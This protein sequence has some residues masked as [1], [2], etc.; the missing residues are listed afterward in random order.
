M[1]KNIV[2]I[3]MF[4]VIGL[5]QTN[6]QCY[7]D[8]HST[9]W[10]DGWISCDASVNP[11]PVHGESH[12]IMYDL[13]YDYVL[14]ETKLWNA[15]EPSQL[16]NGI[17]NYTID[18][19]LDGATWTNLGNFTMTQANGLSTYEGEDGPDLNGIKARF[20]LITPTSNYGGNCYGFSEAKFN[21]TDPFEVVDEEDGFNASVYP[22]PFI[23]NVNLR[24]VSL[25][26]DKPITYALHDILGRTI[27]QNV[28]QMIPDTNTY[29]IGLKGNTLAIGIYILNI[30]QNGKQRSFKLIKEN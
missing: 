14:N 29:E 4:F 30:K 28:L 16:N 12:W 15:N 3:L 7:P 13:N 26:E 24:I 6:A 11:N 10:F 21:I 20:I 17:Q 25:F 22:N 1:N 19:S 8:R 23:N 27:T 2:Y 9:S 18:Y 5:Q